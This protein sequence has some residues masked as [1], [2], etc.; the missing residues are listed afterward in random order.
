MITSRN[1]SFCKCGG[2]IYTIT[3]II[4][5]TTTIVTIITIIIMRPWRFRSAAAWASVFL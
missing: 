5:T 4:I 2:S 1:N 3:S